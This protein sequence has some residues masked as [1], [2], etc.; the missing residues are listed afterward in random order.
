MGKSKKTKKTQK[1]SPK[2][3]PKK[4]TAKSSKDKFNLLVSYDPNHAG[5]AQTELNEALNKIGEKPKIKV[6]EVE[7]LFKVNVSDARKV[8]KRLT[9]LCEADPNL[10]AATF[11][12]TPIDVWCKSEVSQIQKHIKKAASDID[13]SESW[14]LGLNKRHWTKMDGTKLIIKLTEV[15]DLK[16]VDLDNPKKIVQ[17]EIIGKEAGISLLRPDEILNVPKVKS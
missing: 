4:T 12:Y 6:S 10:F 5:L 11:H 16:N 7:G 8:V 9:N 15:I 13:E 1:K 2:K 3:A 14:K 17:V